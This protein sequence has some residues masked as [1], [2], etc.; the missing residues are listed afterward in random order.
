MVHPKIVAVMR[1]V[2]QER[3]LTLGDGKEEEECLFLMAERLQEV[4][5]LRLIP[6][7]S[8]EECRSAMQ[9]E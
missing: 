2:L 8:W 6:W 9:Q 3:G 4:S 7:L 5:G 1:A